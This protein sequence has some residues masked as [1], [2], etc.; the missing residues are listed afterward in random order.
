MPA[1]S[2]DLAISVFF[3]IG[4]AFGYI[5]QREKII[6]TLLSVYVALVITQVFSGNVFEFFQGNKTIGSVWVQSGASPFTV[7]VIIFMAVITLLSAKGGIKGSTTKGLLSPIE[8]LLLS[9][10]TTGLILSSIFYFMPPES[11]EAFIASSRLA[12]LVI[13]YYIWWVVAPPLALIGLGF[14]RRSSSD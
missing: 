1:P 7:R 2:W 4:M 10:L 9:F 12:G 8:I 14:F 13:K 3:L 5:L 6:A 11:R